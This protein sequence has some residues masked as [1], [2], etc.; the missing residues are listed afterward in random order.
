[1]NDKVEQAK[2]QAAERNGDIL[3]LSA[4]DRARQAAFAHGEV[5]TR[6]PSAAAAAKEAQDASEP[7]GDEV[8]TPG[9]GWGD[10]GS[11][12]K[13]SRRDPKSI[14]MLL[15]RVVRD[16]GWGQRLEIA[17]VA[18]RWDE[19]VGPN[20]AR[21]CAVESFGDDGVL[22]LRASSTS[23]ETQIKALLAT[24]DQRIAEEVG[25]G[26]VKEIKVLGPYRPSWKHGKYSVP[27]RGPRDT[28]G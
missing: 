6:R 11:G 12:A 23:W 5:R 19:I 2:R 25:E 20:V 18:A 3:A 26:V 7:L 14:S 8:F 24:V 10:V 13:P 17:S 4:L 28:Y 9:P 21:H 27:G 15:S 22:T 1:M 16:H